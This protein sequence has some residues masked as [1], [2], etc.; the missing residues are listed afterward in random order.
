V[1][2]PATKTTARPHLLRLAAEAVELLLGALAAK[3]QHFGRAHLVLASRLVQPQLALVLLLELL[4]LPLLGPRQRRH[5]FQL[6]LARERVLGHAELA[7]VLV[8]HVRQLGVRAAPVARVVL[9]GA[10]QP[11][12]E[13]GRAARALA[14]VCAPHAALDIS[15]AAKHGWEIYTCY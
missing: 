10:P 12:H 9:A 7:A 11:P 4:D 6:P 5:L 3:P 2:E 1:R 8:G 15:P 14:A 13:E